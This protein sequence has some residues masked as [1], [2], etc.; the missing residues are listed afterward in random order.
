MKLLSGLVLMSL[1]LVFS[2]CQ[3]Y[4]Q[5]EVDQANAAIDAARVAE[6]DVYAAD[7]FTALKDSLA[8]VI[9]SV[10]KEKSKLFSNYKEELT[11]LTSTVEMVLCCRKARQKS[12]DERGSYSLLTELV[13][14]ID[15][16]TK[17]IAKLQGAK[18]VSRS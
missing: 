18:K 8:M 3:K 10:E 15:Q 4:P 9:N 11:K 16:N 7:E 17:M 1:A 5:A 6:A 14:I 12:R 13:T 2:S